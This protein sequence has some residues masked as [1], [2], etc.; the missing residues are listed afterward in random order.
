MGAP[1]E[2]GLTYR[3]LVADDYPGI[4]SLLVSDSPG[5]SACDSEERTSAFL[6]R[7]SSYCFA[8]VCGGKLVGMI[9]CGCD[10]RSARIY[11]LI[12]GAEWRR[13][14]VA[15]T[16][17]GLTY[18]ALRSEGIAVMDVVVFR[19]APDTEFWESEGFRD[20]SDLAYRDFALYD[21]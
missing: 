2:A 20:R 3:T 11:H 14:G 7:N 15:H 5:I 9:M 8:A 6:A 21:L 16:L 13:R 10:G 4:R 19:E 1:T 17:I 12:V 18:D